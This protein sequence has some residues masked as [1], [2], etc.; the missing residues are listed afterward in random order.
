MVLVLGSLGR[1]EGGC[2]LS[3]VLILS[4]VAIVETVHGANLGISRVGQ[5]LSMAVVLGSV[6]RD[7][8]CPWFWD[9]WGRGRNCPRF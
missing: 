5:Q 1:G 7:R 3:T 4:L 2:E 8:N 9:Q 6:E